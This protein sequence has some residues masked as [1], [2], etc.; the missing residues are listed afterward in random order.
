MISS[1]NCCF[2]LI[3]DLAKENI[4]TDIATIHGLKER[5]ELCGSKSFRSYATQRK[6]R[7]QVPDLPACYA[8]VKQRLVTRNT[9]GPPGLS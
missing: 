6:N 5:Q 1:V 9:V 2:L 4:H 7:H 8:E 3:F